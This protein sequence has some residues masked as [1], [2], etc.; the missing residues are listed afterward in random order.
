MV[1]H[2]LNKLEQA[3]RTRG[4]DKFEIRY[5]CESNRVLKVY[6][7]EVSEARD[8]S[9]QGISLTVLFNGKKG[10]F[11]TADFDEDK[12]S[13]V[14]DEALGNAQAVDTEETFFFHDGSGDYKEVKQYQPLAQLADLDKIQYLKDL[15]RLAYEADARINKVIT[16]YYSEGKSRL[17]IR[18][19]LGLNLSREQEE[20]FAYLYL[21]AKEGNAIKTDAEGVC[22]NRLQD[23]NPATI[24]NTVV[25]RLLSRS[26][27]IDIT[28][29]KARV[30]FDHDVAGDVLKALK[31][32]FSS[33]HL[34]S[35]ATKLKGKIGQKVA[36][37]LV[38]IAD[39]PWLEGG[40]AT[41]SFDG[42]GVPTKYKELVK[43]GILQ[44]F[45]YG[46]ALAAKHQTETTGNGAGG[47]QPLFFNFYLKNGSVS[48]QAMLRQLNNGVYIDK[49]HGIGVGISLV[50]GDFSFGAEGF[51]VENGKI[52]KALNQF[53]ISGNIYDFLQDIEAV[54]DDLD[55]SKSAVASPS[56]LVKNLTIANS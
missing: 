18:N 27:S 2:Y 8:N 45:V 29:Q 51:M 43:D 30:I 9:S 49:L 44:G 26:P 28:T 47:L 41:R 32:I 5:V 23:F 34:D 36:S 22:F 11:E 37:P 46:M 52:T 6:E 21:S 3:C 54:G 14:V 17:I 40:L 25:P 48:R 1:E 55:L 16:T 56:L 4:I 13:L 19:S 50:S 35:G 12:I 7:Q 20:A 15:E 53:T 33:F 38:T 24:I 31:G 39:D 10:R 42:E